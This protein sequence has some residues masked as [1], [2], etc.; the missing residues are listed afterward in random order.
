MDDATTLGFQFAK[1]VA[2]QLIALSTGLLTLTITFTKDI[3]RIVPR[4]GRLM[5]PFAWATHLASVCFGVLALMALTGTLMPA[6]P[7]TRNLEF[8]P[9]VRWMAASQIVTFA[10]GTAFLF[11]YGLLAFRIPKPAA[12]EYRSIVVPLGQLDSELGKHLSEGWYL[13]QVVPATDG[14]LLLL[15][16][17][18]NARGSVFSP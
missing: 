6:G 10:L 4:R 5:L 8:G 11:I 12:L 9:N 2:T 16:G 18:G 3:F 1:E 17:K 15:F 13:V 7:S 14:Q